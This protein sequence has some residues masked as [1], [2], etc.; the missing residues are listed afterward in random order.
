MI[1]KQEITIESNYGQNGEGIQ[2]ALFDSDWKTDNAPQG[3][4]AGELIRKRPEETEID[5]ESVIDEQKNKS[6]IERKYGVSSNKKGSYKYRDG[7]FKFDS[8]NSLDYL[9]SFRSDRAHIFRVKAPMI[10]QKGN[11]SEEGKLGVVGY[12][13][14]STIVNYQFFYNV[15]AIS[16][17]EGVRRIKEGLRIVAEKNERVNNNP[18]CKEL[19][20]HR[21]SK[22]KTE[23]YIRMPV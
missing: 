5:G 3:F 22:T 23:Y 7:G 6:Y 16:P 8:T 18:E 19:R 17:K 1:K 14:N 11:Q 13:E 2:I 10:S 20:K 4:I 12:A 21:R 15:P 9:A